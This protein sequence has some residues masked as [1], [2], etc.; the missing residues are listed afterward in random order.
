MLST[1]QIGKKRQISLCTQ[2][3]QRTKASGSH[4]IAMAD[5]GAWEDVYESGEGVEQLMKRQKLVYDE[6]VNNVDNKT[7]KYT[8]RKMTWLPDDI[9][10]S[11]ERK[12]VDF[13]KYSTDTPAA[14][15]SGRYENIAFA[16][17]QDINAGDVGKSA[18]TTVNF[19]PNNELVCTG[20]LDAQVRIFKVDCKA[21]EKVHTLAVD[22]PVF[23]AE[24]GGASSSDY[25]IIAG[26]QKLIFGNLER[27]VLEKVSLM[28]GVCTNGSFIQSPD[29]AF[30]GVIGSSQ[31]MLISQKS[32]T[33]VMSLRS[34]SRINAVAFDV[35]GH[36]V[37]GCT[38]D[39]FLHY[40]DI[41]TQRC[42]KSASGFD[43]VKRL[44]IPR[45]SGEI[46]TGCSNGL[47]RVFSPESIDWSDARHGKKTAQIAGKTLSNLCTEITTIQTSPGSDIVT[48]ASSLKR[49]CLRLLHLPRLKVIENWPTASTPLHYVSSCALNFDGSLLAIGNARGQVLAYRIST[50]K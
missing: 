4:F 48:F 22:T 40:W 39:G 1:F 6:T 35:D 14:E 11:S 41:R 23:Q 46:I 27:R 33:S 17:V 49:N 36:Q 18:V 37:A 3:A 30:V 7:R 16:R 19:H 38:D 25:I 28:K 8:R 29:S 43:G 21:N 12:A 32:R 26:K 20:G 15:P 45:T 2:P 34:N 24:F 5:Q 50:P 47:M 44:C 9:A 31:L 10:H 42:I 13:V